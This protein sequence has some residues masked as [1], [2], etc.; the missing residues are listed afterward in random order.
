MSPRVGW[1]RKGLE[2]IYDMCVGPA[3]FLVLV[4]TLHTF[5]T[6]L[7]CVLLPEAA[8]VNMVA[9]IF[10]LYKESNSFWKTSENRIT[11]FSTWRWHNSIHR[12]TWI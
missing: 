3:M 4:L 5:E 8:L 6:L 10:L 2:T 1:N 11:I 7:S 9:A 12:Q